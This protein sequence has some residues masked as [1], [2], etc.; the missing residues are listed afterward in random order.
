MSL[1]SFSILGMLWI[2]KRQKE[3]KWLP[4]LFLNTNRLEAFKIA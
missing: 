1:F 4:K 2:P 3:E